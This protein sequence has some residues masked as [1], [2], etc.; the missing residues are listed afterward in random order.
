MTCLSE[1]AVPAVLEAYDFAG[2]HTLMDVAGGHGALLRAILHKHPEMR[3]IIIDLDHIVDGA[4]KLPE[5]QALAHRCEFLCAD[6]FA[7]VPTSADA[8]IMKHIIHDWDDDKAAVILRNCR[9]ALAGKANAKI[10]LVES[11]LPA[12]NE[13][14]LG[15]FIDLE[16]VGLSRGA[17]AHGARVPQTAVGR[18]GYDPLATSL[19]ARP[20][21]GR[22]AM[23]P[24][25]SSPALLW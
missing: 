8:I 6:F 21:N 17:R 3:G 19:F 12:G 16:N 20:W 14:H 5:N 15:K 24:T 23:N 13:P 2:I 7:E 4:K 1:M 10:I 18:G 22:R 25:L 9:R 11:V